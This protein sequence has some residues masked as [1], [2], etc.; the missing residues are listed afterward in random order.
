MPKAYFNAGR[1]YNAALAIAIA[2]LIV[3]GC[4]Q[5][6]NPIPNF[7]PKQDKLE[8]MLAFGLFAATLAYALP[9]RFALGAVA[10]TAIL[11]VAIEYGQKIWVP[12]REF[13]YTDAAAGI[14]GAIVAGALALALFAWQER[15]GSVSFSEDK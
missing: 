13:S 6:E 2:A 1:V 15:Y 7:F 5:P 9:R 12:T 11:A 10:A 14:F 4:L 3:W 8:H